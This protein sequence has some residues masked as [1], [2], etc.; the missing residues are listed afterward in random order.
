M[1]MFI[2]SIY[3]LRLA[4]FLKEHLPERFLLFFISILIA[5]FYL[6]GEPILLHLLCTKAF[7]VKDHTFMPCALHLQR[8]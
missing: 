8:P 5:I 3:F 4:R 1:A 6:S 2:L 7:A